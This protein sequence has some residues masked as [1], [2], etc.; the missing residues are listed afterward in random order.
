MRYCCIFVYADSCD[1]YSNLSY[2]GIFVMNLKLTLKYDGTC[3]H[4]WQRQPNGI[5]VQEILEDT[6]EKVMKKKIVD[7]WLISICKD[8]IQSLCDVIY[9]KFQKALE[10]LHLHIWLNFLHQTLHLLK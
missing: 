3:Y 9:P 7:K 1:Y 8:T 10:M 2:G 4:G 5:T 6:L